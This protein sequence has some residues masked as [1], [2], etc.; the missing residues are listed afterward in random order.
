[1]GNVKGDWQITNDF[2]AMLRYNF[3]EI[4]EVRETK[5]AKGYTGDI[6]GAYGIND[7]LNNEINIDFLITYAKKFNAWDFLA[8]VGGNKRSTKSSSDSN[9]TKNGGSG[10]LAPG[11]VALSN[12]APDNLNYASYKSEREVNSLYGLVSIGFKD[13]F[14]IDATGRNDWSSTLPDSN[15]AY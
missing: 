3:D 6:N 8:S 13:M 1:Y 15:N 10:I 11:L 12:I 14:Y 7:I 9:S 4:N 2:S 5:M